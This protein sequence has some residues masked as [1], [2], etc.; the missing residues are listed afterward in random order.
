[1]RVLVIA[2]VLGL[3]AVSAFARLDHG[4]PS[5]VDVL[6]GELARMRTA[7]DGVMKEQEQIRRLLAQHPSLQAQPSEA[8]ARV[9]VS[10]SPMLGDPEAPV[11]LV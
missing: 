7:L 5:E 9:S 6:K 11:T 8:V 10:G 2:T 3:G 1:M 4:P